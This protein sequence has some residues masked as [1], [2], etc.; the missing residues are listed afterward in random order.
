[1]INKNLARNLFLFLFIPI[2]SMIPWSKR[3]DF[4]KENLM[5]NPTDTAMSVAHALIFFSTVACIVYGLLH[6]NN[7]EQT[8]PAQVDPDEDTQA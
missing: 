8:E 3:Y 4:A 7:Q 1:M 5:I 2:Y 6:W